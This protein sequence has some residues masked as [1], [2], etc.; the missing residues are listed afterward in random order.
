ML[1]PLNH[2]HQEV[3]LPGDFI[4]MVVAAGVGP[5]IRTSLEKAGLY[6]QG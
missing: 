3:I 6:P 5:M 4:K 2:L 1:L